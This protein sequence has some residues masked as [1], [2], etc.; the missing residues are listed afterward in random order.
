VSLEATKAKTSWP[1]V[2]VTDAP[3]DELA[4]NG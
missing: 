3:G 1:Q 4:P 2:R